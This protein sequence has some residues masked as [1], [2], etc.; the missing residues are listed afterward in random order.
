MIKGSCG[1]K[2]GDFSQYVATLAILVTISIVIS[3]I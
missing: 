2:G 3:E 1:L